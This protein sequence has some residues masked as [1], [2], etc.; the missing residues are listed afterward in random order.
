MSINFNNI[1]DNMR[2]P[3]CYMEFDNSKAVGGTPDIMHKVLVLG[4]MLGTGTATAEEPVR[5]LTADHASNL[6]GRGSMLASMFDAIKGADR[7]IE[8]WAIPVVDAAAAAAATK[9]ITIG[10]A[11]TVS[12]TLNLYIAGQ[13]VRTAITSGD[14]AATVATALTAS[15]NAALDLPVTA[16]AAEAVVT[17]TAR[18]KGES[19]NDIDVRTNYYPGEVLPTGITVAIAVGTA[20]TANPNLTDAIAAF[21]DEWWNTF[22]MPYTDAANIVA[23]EA[24][25]LDR[26]GPLTQK[27]GL[28]YAAFK[29]THSATGTWGNGRNNQLISCM[30]IGQTPTPPWVFAA[31]YGVVAAA[32][33]SIDPARPLQTL[34]LPGVLAPAPGDRWTKEERNLLL[35]D[36]IAT[37]SVGTDGTVRIE[38]EITTYQKNVY[39]LDDPSYLYVQTPA[40]LGY[41]RH[42][43]NSRITQ[44]FPR[45]K[46]ADDGTKFGPGQAIVTPSIIRVEL[47]ALMRELEEKGLV[48][49]LDQLIKDLVVE[50]NDDNR[51]RVDVLSPPDL[52]NQFRMLAEL[53]Q[54]RQ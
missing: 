39:G 11:A 21:G 20:G 24:E 22:I 45:H 2:V 44:K 36:G 16:S 10:G 12:G 7:Y 50:R 52:V 54:Y 32:S 3:L 6:F 1:P 37:Y 31:V 38:G 47:I 42:A 5:V 9:T 18:H 4:Q 34:T 48:E 27:E 43:T 51:N 25:L 30:G 26:W 14:A 49:N 8:T 19:G 15:I 53:V 40:T 33:L 35:Y 17:L 41:I 46:L 28:A 23:L 29:G 13:R